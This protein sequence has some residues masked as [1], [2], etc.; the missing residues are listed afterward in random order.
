MYE[1]PD[2]MTIWSPTMGE[3]KTF[4]YL[5]NTVHHIEYS[6]TLVTGYILL[7]HSDFEL[8]WMWSFDLQ[9]YD[10]QMNYLKMK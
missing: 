5:Y 3:K 9:Q 1:L 10:M 4:A 2:D 8:L 7:Y 6:I